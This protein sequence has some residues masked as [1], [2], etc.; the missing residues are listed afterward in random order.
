MSRKKIVFSM[1]A[2]LRIS[3]KSSREAPKEIENNDM[4]TIMNKPGDFFVV[5]KA[6]F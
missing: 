6:N 1:C 5:S 4:L 2:A 3:T